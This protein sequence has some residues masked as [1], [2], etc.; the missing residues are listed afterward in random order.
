MSSEIERHKSEIERLKNAFDAK[1][2]G[3]NQFSDE[4]R[5]LKNIIAENNVT[6]SKQRQDIEF[7]EGRTK[8]L[9]QLI[10]DYNNL[11]EQIKNV[12]GI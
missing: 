3:F 1:V 5:Q 12:M 9:K 6:I 10:S 11:K 7:E 8:R 4:I 2:E